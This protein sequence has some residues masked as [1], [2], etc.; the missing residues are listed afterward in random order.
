MKQS[1]PNITALTAPGAPFEVVNVSVLG[2]DMRVFK[3]APKNLAD[4][5]QGARRHG[6]A[7]FVTLGETR[8]TFR[9]FFDQADRLSGWL[10]NRANISPGQSV[11]ICMKNCPEWMAA[12]VAI[13]N[14][15][16]VPVSVNSRDEGAVMSHAVDDADSVFVIADAKRLRALREAG[17]DLPAICVG[18][19]SDE[20]PL[21]VT[22]YAD[23]MTSTPD[24]KS[25]A[26]KTDDPAAMFF[27][28]GTTGRAKA[29]VMTHRNIITG[30]LTTQMAIA[31]I[32]MTMAEQYGMT[33][34]ALKAHMP[35]SCSAMIFPLFHVSGCISTFL[36]SL[37]SGG[38]LVMMNRWD[39]EEALR[40]IETEKISSFGGVP[41]MHWDLVKAAKNTKHDLSSLRALSCG[42]QALPLGLLAEIRETFPNV[43]IGAGYGMTEASGAVSQATGEGITSRPKAS[44]QKLAMIDIKV[45]DDEGQ[46]LPEGE[47]GEF[48]VRGPTVIREYHR[49]PEANAKAFKKGW[50]RTGDIGKL[51]SDGYLTVVD[52]KTDMVISG[53]ENIYCAEVEQALGRHPAVR[54]VTTFGV[55]DDRLGERLVAGFVIDGQ[56]TPDEMMAYARDNLAAYKLP[57]DIILQA[58]SFELNAMGKVEKHKVRAAYLARKEKEQAA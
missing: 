14:I 33:V 56:V 17:C 5:F 27:T 38:K 3:N 50:Y 37:A 24:Y 16:A 58:N 25:I 44:G 32:S 31:S 48:W 53:G 2:H 43:I 12:F 4:I 45:T 49:R 6:E 41:T 23:V 1:D 47:I 22:S 28:S 29:A 21:G 20:A 51:D 11:A 15:G 7:E 30:L 35:Q 39:A 10:Q 9:A 55:A 46:E 18:D 26:R 13:S 8:L 40:L 52:R 42:G 34:E 36:S 57:T 19:E 54:Q